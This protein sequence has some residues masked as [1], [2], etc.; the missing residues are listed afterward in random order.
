MIQEQLYPTYNT[1][2][3]SAQITNMLDTFTPLTYGC[4]DGM[5]LGSQLEYDPKMNSLHVAI[6]HVRAL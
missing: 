3:I 1:S 2:V 5:L 6:V 4:T